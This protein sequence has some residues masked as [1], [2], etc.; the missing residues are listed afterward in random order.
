MN[1]LL[2]IH[3]EYAA[4]IYAGEKN[5]EL[6]TTIPRKYELCEDYIFIYE[7]APIFA[8]T[9][10]MKVDSYINVNKILNGDRKDLKRM[11]INE[12]C[13]T[14]EQIKDYKPNLQLWGWNID[15]SY[16]FGRKE[17]ITRFSP[18]EKPPQ[19]WCYTRAELQS[20]ICLKFDHVLTKKSYKKEIE[21]LK[22]WE[23]FKGGDKCL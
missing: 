8:V 17:F 16:N 21:I 2:S 23:F 7:T 10:W 15:E 22:R 3:P 12:S 13:L 11:I 19:S 20:E 6:R 14:M 5:I 4:M 1:L 18:N 9:G